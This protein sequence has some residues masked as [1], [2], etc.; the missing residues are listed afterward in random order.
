MFPVIGSQTL[1]KFKFVNSELSY[2]NAD[3][4]KSES[5]LQKETSER[6]FKPCRSEVRKSSAEPFRLRS[7]VAPLRCLLSSAGTKL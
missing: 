2:Q 7:Q 5:N 6:G 3:S 4:R 1:R